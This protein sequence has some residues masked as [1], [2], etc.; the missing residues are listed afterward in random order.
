MSVHSLTIETLSPV[1][2]G[3]GGPDLR[4]NIDFAIF[5]KTLYMLNID[6]VLEAMLPENPNDR[7]YQ[8]ILNAPDLGSLVT[9]EQLIKHPELY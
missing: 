1:H 3:A 6:A 9:A 2:I 7:Y 4:R 5:G 8:Q